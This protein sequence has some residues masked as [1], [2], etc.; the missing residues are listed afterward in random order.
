MFHCLHREVEYRCL[1]RSVVK[2]CKA[3][4]KDGWLLES[5]PSLRPI[6]FASTTTSLSITR[7]LRFA[8]KN[9]KILSFII[10][11]FAT[12][13][14]VFGAQMKRKRSFI[15]HDVNSLWRW[16]WLCF[17]FYL[18]KLFISNLKQ[19]SFFWVIE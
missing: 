18:K 19:W 16:L 10:C 5:I 3:S 11:L 12:I 7:N 4:L 15:A 17:K 8:R 2:S 6:P 9:G 13:L 1:A 14:N